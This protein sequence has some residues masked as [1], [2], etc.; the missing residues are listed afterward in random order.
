[1][2]AEQVCEALRREID[3]ALQEQIEKK[4]RGM[5][6]PIIK[7]VAREI[8]SSV[9]ANVFQRPRDYSNPVLNLG[10]QILLQFN[11][12]PFEVVK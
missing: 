4:V 1:M 5:A 2:N 10:E 7:S 9:K 6:E 8:A 3:R 12:E 11:L